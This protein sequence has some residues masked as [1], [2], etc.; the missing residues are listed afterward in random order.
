LNLQRIKNSSP[1]SRIITYSLLDAYTIIVVHEKRH[2]LQAR[3]V[4]DSSGFPRSASQALHRSSG[5]ECCG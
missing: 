5:N 2:F 4:L 1:V 3:R